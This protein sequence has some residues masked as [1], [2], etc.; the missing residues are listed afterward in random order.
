MGHRLHGRRVGSTYW[1]LDIT[2]G[3]VID[4][5]MDR[6]L[7]PDQSPRRLTQQMMVSWGVGT[8]GPVTVLT[9]TNALLLRFMTDFYGLAA[10]MAASLIAISKFYDVFA[11][12][13][14]GIV[15]DRTVTRWGR[16]RP[17][18]ILGAMLLVISVVAIFAAPP[19]VSLQTRTIY[20]GAILIFYATAYSVFNIPYMAMPGEM[21]G[22]YHERTEL[23]T[24]RVYAVGLSTIIAT[25]CGPILLDAFGGKARA[26]AG[27]SLVFAPIVLGA[28]IVTFYGTARAPATT[29]PLHGPG[30]LNQMASAF[31]NRPFVALIVV[32]FIT[33]MS[34]GLQ[35]IFPFFFQRIL[36]VSNS[37][38][39]YYFLCQSVM[40]LGAATP[41]RWLSLRI[42]KKA[43]FMI[44]LA[45]S[46]PIWISWQFAG[47]GE[48]A[49]LIYLR[50]LVVGASG[51]GVILMG[52]SMLPDTMAYDYQRTGLRREGI[53]AALYTTVE[54]LS[55]ALG[56]A[57]VGAVLSA[58][59]YIQSR[60]ATVVQPASALWA[61]RFIM[62]W[63]PTFITMLG[64]VAL[65]AYNL[66]EA[67]LTGIVEPPA[68]PIPPPA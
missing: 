60:G 42:G 65:L 21:S 49:P 64:M 2:G 16:R 36:G 27:M 53:F 25:V 10:G 22:S 34:L 61:I 20:M 41:W 9:A 15:S 35:S 63:I 45:L 26:Y 58:F 7:T 3:G 48:P 67:K 4:R 6:Y 14:M 23:M 40:L 1:S 43:T 11:D 31:S 59:G 37:V 19:F 5:S 28:G 54:K 8:L 24:W 17:F 13:G 30:F 29:R 12:V 47:H 38:L 62:A 68:D 52:Q 39:G 44:A 18:L 33:L 51:S 55:G 32:K 50:G 46:V 57:L 66:D 56:V